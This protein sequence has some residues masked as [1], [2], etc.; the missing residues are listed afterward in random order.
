[1][2]HFFIP[3][4]VLIGLGVGLIAGYPG[5]GVLIGLGLGLIGSAFQTGECA[6]P[7]R[8]SHHGISMI[9]GVFLI[10]VG[11]GYGLVTGK[12]LAVSCRR[13]PDSARVVVP[14]T[15]RYQNRMIPIFFDG[16]PGSF[17]FPVQPCMERRGGCGCGTATCRVVVCRKV[18][19][20]SASIRRIYL[21]HSI[22]AGY[23]VHKSPRQPV[24]PNHIFTK[25]HAPYLL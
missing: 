6:E 20:P 15:R 5:A 12:P 16:Y 24:S 10:L 17:R 3:A 21:P 13:L 1:M 25:K 11:I 22:P 14:G 8:C 9:V 18:Y 2:K 4:G 23:P 7:S 19:S